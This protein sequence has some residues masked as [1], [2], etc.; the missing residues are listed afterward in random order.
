LC[1]AGNEGY[2]ERIERGVHILQ[3]SAPK[4]EILGSLYLDLA[5]PSGTTLRIFLPAR[6]LL[7]FILEEDYGY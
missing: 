7:T 6:G 3:G 2:D 1:T 4:E 5:S